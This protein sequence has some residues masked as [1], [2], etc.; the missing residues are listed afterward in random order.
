MYAIISTDCSDARLV[1]VYM[2]T[3]SV[4]MRNLSAS[5]DSELRAPEVAE[6]AAPQHGGEAPALLRG[7]GDRRARGVER[8]D[9]GVVVGLG[10]ARS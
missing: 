10:C 1:S 9:R 8:R 7:S 6:V 2:K 4:N 5:C 3:S